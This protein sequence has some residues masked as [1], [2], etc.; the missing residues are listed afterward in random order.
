MDANLKLWLKNLFPQWW[1][2]SSSI[3]VNGGLRWCMPKVGWK[4][5]RQDLVQAQG[6]AFLNN[7]CCWLWWAW[8]EEFL[9]VRS[10]D[11]H[12]SQCCRHLQASS[13]HS[14]LPALYSPWD[15]SSDETCFPSSS[16]SRLLG[17]VAL[18]SRITWFFSTHFW[19]GSWDDRT[20]PPPTFNLFSFRHYPSPA[21]WF[22]TLECPLPPYLFLWAPQI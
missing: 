10:V 5:T 17:P 22:R 11:H 2:W 7:N 14:N 9:F 21:A 8:I 1:Q 3:N 4:A 12:T 18:P 19:P 15:L 16:S 6:D 13:I 20:W